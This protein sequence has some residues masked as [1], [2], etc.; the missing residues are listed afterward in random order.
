MRNSQGLLL[1]MQ[2]WW[3]ISTCT[4]MFHSIHLNPQCFM[5][6]LLHD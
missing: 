3:P 6:S 5:P 1:L 4:Q 2:Q